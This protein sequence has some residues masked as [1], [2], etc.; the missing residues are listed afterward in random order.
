MPDTINR[1][2]A[3]KMKEMNFAVF[4]PPR[5]FKDESL[6]SVRMFL[7]KWGVQYKIASYGNSNCTGYHGSICR[8]DVDA[9][10]INPA[11]YD[12]IIIVDGLGI[13]STRLYEFRPLLDMVMLFNSAGR[14]IVAMGNAVK[15]LARANIIKN[16]RVSVR[17]PEAKR[18]V[19]LF[20]GV[21]T[22]EP[23][24]ISDGLIT[25]D[26]QADMEGSMKKML[27]SLGII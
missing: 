22:E 20:H 23:I 7:E 16:R 18:L 6:S 21:P 12:G 14:K 24:E 2:L 8:K 1:Q 10:K 4:V 3:G 15:I 17:D 25:I 19:T 26:S 5:E 13:D 9:L 11:D 27:S